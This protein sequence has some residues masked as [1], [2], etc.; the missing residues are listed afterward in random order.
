M[1]LSQEAMRNGKIFSGIICLES[2]SCLNGLSNFPPIMVQIWTDKIPIKN[3]ILTFVKT[4]KITFEDTEILS[5][6]LYITNRE[7]TIC[8]MME[9]EVTEEFICQSLETYFNDRSKEDLIPYVI[10]YTSMDKYNHYLA[11]YDE[12]LRGEF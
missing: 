3:S 1:W 5:H 12:Y 4:D 7:R 6:N 9:R 8:E 2:A 10:K 11:L